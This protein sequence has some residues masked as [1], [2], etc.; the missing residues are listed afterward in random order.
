MKS[1]GEAVA[2]NHNIKIESSVTVTPTRQQPKYALGASCPLAMVINS[3]RKHE[4]RLSGRI[5]TK[6]SVYL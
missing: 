5:I 1:I 6:Y 3:I 4:I 2:K